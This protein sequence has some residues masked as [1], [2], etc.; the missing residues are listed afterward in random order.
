MSKIRIVADYI[1]FLKTR[2]KWWILPII[3]VL[4]ALGLLIV[5]TE[6]SILAPFI[7]PLF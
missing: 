2:K 5:L 7:Y 1:V 3:I 6:G 4:F